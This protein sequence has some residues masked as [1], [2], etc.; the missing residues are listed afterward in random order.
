MEMGDM[1]GLPAPA[2]PVAN[3]QKARC[4]S[5]WAEFQTTDT[6]T[7]ALQAHAS[8]PMSLPWSRRSLPLAQHAQKH[9]H[10]HAHTNM[11]THTHAHIH[12]HPHSLTHTRTH[13]HTN[14]HTHTHIHTCTHKHSGVSF[15]LFCM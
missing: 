6:H 3:H 1:Q 11:L 15:S 4:P 14:T 12:T 5:L 10:T 9:A 7:R 2:T 8:T 13:T